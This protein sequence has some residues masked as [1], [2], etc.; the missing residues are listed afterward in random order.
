MTRV[1]DF[2]GVTVLEA[3][4][5]GAMLEDDE[6]PALLAR[7]SGRVVLADYGEEPLEL[8]SV[9]EGFLVVGED[10]AVL[11][12][13]EG[14]VRIVEH[15]EGDLENDPPGDDLDEAVKVSD[16]EAKP[17]PSSPKQHLVRYRGKGVAL[18]SPDGSGFRIESVGKDKTGRAVGGRI[19]KAN[20]MKAALAL[21][22][23]HLGEAI[24]EAS[25]RLGSSG[26]KAMGDL[27]ARYK[28]LVADERDTG[29]KKM[30]AGDLKDY[31][32][33]L[34]LLKVG[35]IKEARKLASS[36]D[37]AARDEIPDSVYYGMMGYEESVDDPIDEGTDLRCPNCGDN[38]G[39]DTENPKKAYCGNCGKD[40]IRNPRGYRESV[41][42][43][44]VPKTKNEGYGFFGSLYT[45]M[46]AQGT[47]D[48][49]PYWEAVFKALQK[50]WKSKGYTPDEIRAVLDSK[51]GR[52]MV[53]RV[54]ALAKSG[55]P[56][57]VAK[58]ALT[59]PHLDKTAAKEV[60]AFRKDPSLYEADAG[61][62]TLDED[63]GDMQMFFNVGD[64]L[65]AAGLAK[66]GQ[67]MAS[68]AW[69]DIARHISDQP[70]WWKVNKSTQ[71]A[72][73]R[74]VKKDRALAR[75]VSDA[76]ESCEPDE[77]VALRICE[78]RDD[79]EFEFNVPDLLRLTGITQPGDTI[80]AQTWTRVMK[81][82]RNSPL[83]M[84]ANKAAQD[85][86]VAGLKKDRKFTSKVKAA[87]E[88]HEPE[89]DSMTVI[90]EAVLTLGEG[91]IELRAGDAEGDAL[92]ELDCDT[93]APEEVRAATVL[94]QEQAE[95]L[96]YEEEIEFPGIDEDDEEA[97]AAAIGELEDDTL[98]A[99]AS[100]LSDVLG[101]SANEHLADIRAFD[102]AV[103]ECDFENA[104]RRAEL[105][106]AS[107]GDEV[108][109][110]IKRMSRGAVKAR[111]RNAKKRTPEERK[112]ARKAA[113]R[114]K[115]GKA[116]AQA[117]R[118]AKK[119]K[120]RRRQLRTSEEPDET[121]EQLDILDEKKGGASGALA[122]AAKGGKG[123]DTAL[124]SACL[125]Y[126]AQTMGKSTTF[127]SLKKSMAAAGYTGAKGA[128]DAQMMKVLSRLVN[129]GTLK[130]AKGKGY[131]ANESIEDEIAALESEQDGGDEE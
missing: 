116:K 22:A 69:T 72:L 81:W 90:D 41:D 113:R 36:M 121:G 9:D 83:W 50:R 5:M 129:K 68:G 51:M 107:L 120:A 14:G 67:Q 43:A 122:T 84:Q 20:D 42:E 28:K 2:F 110:A 18:I 115:T 86:L 130:Y 56:A 8:Y 38:L 85:V 29:M 17:H 44:R 40:N 47:E 112:A 64:L 70:Y 123:A 101:A 21:V 1:A 23:K 92:I 27:I 61:T 103:E 98:D 114:R 58:K 53:D 16:L 55:S 82:V 37:T 93:E 32:K 25:Q 19:G 96:G 13:D 111:A 35:K 87:L 94:V 3:I 76:L 124:I 75:M 127:G 109:E 6:T 7:E 97:L 71:S 48:V 131:S 125:G 95:E 117:R 89:D 66:K 100:L 104:L 128:T 24:H 102:S 99:I 65:L 30:Y 77:G 126:F 80:P 63:Y 33:L 46:N 15:K 12:E 26:V 105:I 59:T 39:K 4:D 78:G 57:E 31:E 108:L 10:H 88:S 79:F 106:G 54:G 73:V 60:A 49:E 62:A 119:Y 52:Y 11:F 74:E 91:K 118:Y 34:R 45:Q